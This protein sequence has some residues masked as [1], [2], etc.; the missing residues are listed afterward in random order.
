MFAPFLAII[1][2]SIE[3]KPT[4]DIRNTAGKIQSTFFGQLNICIL[5]TIPTFDSHLSGILTLIAFPIFCFIIKAHTY[6][7]R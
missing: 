4:Y 3:I 7:S 5:S 1:Y 6:G 2:F